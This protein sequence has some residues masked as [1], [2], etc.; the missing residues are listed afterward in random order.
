MK[1]I[2]NKGLDNCPEAVDIRKRVFIEEQG[3]TDEF[4][5]LDRSAYHA[6]VFVKD[7]HAA[8]GRLFSD[9]N[10]IAHIGRVAVLPDFRK[11]SLGS[12]IIAILEKKAAE[13]NFISTELSAQVRVMDFYTKLGYTPVGE[14]YPDQGCPRIKM[15][16]LLR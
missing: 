15:I 5:K 7:Q 12:L 11:M 16:K 2:L 6:V 4:D 13:L 9:K 1:Y 14:E 8:T 10:G 3:F